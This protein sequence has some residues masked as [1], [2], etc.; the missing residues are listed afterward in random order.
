VSFAAPL[1][2]L[3]L[4][5]LPALAA[6]YVAEQ[7]RAVRAA[8]AFASLALAASV[9]PRRPGRRRH[10][11]FIVIALGLAVAIVAIARPRVRVTVPVKAAT[12]MLANDVSDSM[13]STDV[14]PTRLGAAKQAAITFTSV[15]PTSIAIGSIAFARHP[16][17]LQSPSTDH[18]LARAAIS[19]LQPGGGGTAIG[20][21]IEIA[22]LAIKSAPKVDGKHPPG[23]I[24]LLSDGTSN[25]GIGP[26]S[27]S[28]AARKAKVKIYTIAIGTSS[29]TEQDKTKDGTK[30]VP[31]PVNPSELE[32]IAQ[33]TRGTFFAAPDQ[34]RASAIYATLA[35]ELGHRRAYRG[36][37]AEFAGGALVLLVLGG[38][39]SLYWFGRLT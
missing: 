25:V 35:T 12:V 22:L 17:L 37:I 8:G 20:E 26:A 27:A 1:V 34:A 38:G 32:Q 31:V 18:S 28:A 4:L 9:A 6:L 19:K 33:S 30:T 10:I 21:A 14:S 5:V 11:P 15:A 2:L 3:G 36:L 16:M 39:L 29:G 24:V 7:R 13:T 23:A